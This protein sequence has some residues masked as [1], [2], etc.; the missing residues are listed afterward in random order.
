MVGQVTDATAITGSA[1]AFASSLVAIA[2]SLRKEKRDTAAADDVEADRVIALKDTRI[3]ELDRR[4][5]NLEDRLE[6]YGCGE[7][8]HCDNRRPL[9]VTRTRS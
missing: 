2:I 4:V 8:P 7:A 5:T 6:V 1:I 9:R 3:D